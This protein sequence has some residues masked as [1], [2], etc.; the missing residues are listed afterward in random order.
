MPFLNLGYWLDTIPEN[1]TLSIYYYSHRK[2][3][4]LSSKEAKVF[5]AWI[6]QMAQRRR[7]KR[8]LAQ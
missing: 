1:N 8:L 5:T 7:E 6:F 2:A 4:F 3:W